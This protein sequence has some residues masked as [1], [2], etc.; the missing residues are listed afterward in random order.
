MNRTAASKLGPISEILFGVSPRA[1]SRASGVC[2]GAKIHPGEALV[3]KSSPHQKFRRFCFARAPSRSQFVDSFLRN[4]R[5]ALVSRVGRS[6]SWLRQPP[7]EAYRKIAWKL[8]MRHPIVVLRLKLYVY[9]CSLARATG[10]F[11]SHGSFCLV[12]RERPATSLR[13]DTPFF[14]LLWF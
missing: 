10:P 9:R 14:F 6:E 5:L 2:L 1:L 13:E 3:S 8:Q 7:F 4:L 11:S 12:Q